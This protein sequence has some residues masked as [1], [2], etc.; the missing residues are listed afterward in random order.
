VRDSSSPTAGFLKI[1][2]E[3]SF[4]DSNCVVSLLDVLLD[5]V[6]LLLSILANHL[7]RLIA[8]GSKSLLQEISE[9][10]L[11][12]ESFKEYTMVRASIYLNIR[13]RKPNIF[14]L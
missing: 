13:I 10:L 14:F 12:I 7:H 6:D 5:V 4:P 11:A 3:F 1:Q 2:D 8:E 9:K